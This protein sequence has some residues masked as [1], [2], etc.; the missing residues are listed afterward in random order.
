M[1][2]KIKLK[3]GVIIEDDNGRIFLQKEKFSRNLVHKWNIITGSFEEKDNCMPDTAIRE[4]K[5]EANL[6]IKLTGIF[7][8]LTINK[9]GGYKIYVIFTAKPLSGHALSHQSLQEKFGES[10]IEQKWFT[11]E[12]IANINKSDFVTSSL[13]A[14]ISQYASSDHATIMPLLNL[15]HFEGECYN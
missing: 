7:Q 6:D 14:T 15:Q 1:N 11:K 5:E 9:S 13:A 8:V 12:E 3:I 10:I 2:K 4:C